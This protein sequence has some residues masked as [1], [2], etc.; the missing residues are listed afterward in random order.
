MKPTAKTTR[1]AAPATVPG[2][3]APRVPPIIELRNRQKR[4]MQATLFF[5]QGAPMLLGGD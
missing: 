3:A 5:S 2:I 4:N 1:T